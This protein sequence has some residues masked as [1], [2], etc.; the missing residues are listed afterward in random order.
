MYTLGK[1]AWVK[2]HRGFESLPVRHL[3]DSEQ[4]ARDSLI[5]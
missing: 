5:S 3:R 2:A 1:R 4:V